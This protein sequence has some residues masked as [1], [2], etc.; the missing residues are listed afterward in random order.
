M[1]AAEPTPE[2][3][4][5]GL[6][7]AIDTVKDA[8]EERPALAIVI[9]V[10]VLLLLVLLISLLIVLLRGRKA[11]EEEQAPVQFDEPY[12]PP[13]SPWSPE[14]ADAGIPTTSAPAEDRTEVAPAD[15]SGPDPGVPPFA[16]AAL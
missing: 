10:G 12:T 7:G 1:I 15:W 4:S 16:P 9:G 13:A 11:P 5:D 8:I 3:E 6:Q 2:P 14:P